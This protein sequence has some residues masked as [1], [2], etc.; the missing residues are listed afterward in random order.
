MEEWELGRKGI[1]QIDL[2]NSALLAHLNI[3]Q[4][5]HEGV[6]VVSEIEALF[7]LGWDFFFHFQL[8]IFNASLSSPCIAILIVL[9]S[10]TA[11][12]SWISRIETFG[13]FPSFLQLP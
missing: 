9:W 2:P 11:P 1:A 3:F 7:A 12:F 10:E 6:S 8:D 5:S 13:S 4:F